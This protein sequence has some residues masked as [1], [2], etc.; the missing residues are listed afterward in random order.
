MRPLVSRRLTALAITAALSLGTAGTAF[1][2]EHHPSRPAPHAG[3]RAPLSDADTE[4]LRARIQAAVDAAEAATPG[5]SKPAVPSAVPAAPADLIGDTL[6]LVQ[7]A[8]ADLLAAVTSL[9]PADVVGTVTGTLTSLVDLVTAT[10]GAGGLPK[11]ELP[12]LTGVSQPAVPLPADTPPKLPQAPELPAKP[13][14][15]ELPELPELPVK[16]AVPP[17]R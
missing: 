2:D 3:S 12:G 6:A 8:V 14:A 11:P 1:A 16:P 13:A 5:A 15:P 9:N 4:A 10:L 7:K 17:V